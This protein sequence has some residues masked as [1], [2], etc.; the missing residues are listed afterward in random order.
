MSARYR[1][2]SNKIIQQFI[3]LHR[4]PYH[5]REDR[6]INK[7]SHLLE[8]S[9]FKKAN[10]SITNPTYSGNIET[11]LT[12]TKTVFQKDSKGTPIRNRDGN[13][14]TTGQTATLNPKFSKGVV[15]LP[16]TNNEH[17]TDYARQ[18]GSHWRA[19]KID[20]NKG[21]VSFFNSNHE[22]TNPSLINRLKRIFPTYQYDQHSIH[23][24][25]N[26]RQTDAYTCGDHVMR[27]IA[28]EATGKKLTNNIGQFRRRVNQLLE[29]KSNI[30]GFL[31]NNRSYNPSQSRY[32]SHTADR[33]H[34]AK[35]PVL[36]DIT[37]RPAKRRRISDK[38][39]AT[40]L[41]YDEVRNATPYKKKMTVEEASQ[42]IGD[43]MLAYRMRR[44][45]LNGNGGK[46]R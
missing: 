17:S 36:G 45:E 24:P 44:R 8:Q 25:S 5:W 20:H 2:H 43:A 11:T 7:F 42:I 26:R 6:Q 14:I 12:I 9:G 30:K 27:F 1:R 16:Y 18:H 33:Q 15:L 22:Q 29:G 46:E 21:R 19:I 3:E 31:S 39:I 34:S 4:D 23:V 35:R 38:D 28:E 41:Q 37:N 40:S 10:V 32:S 13:F